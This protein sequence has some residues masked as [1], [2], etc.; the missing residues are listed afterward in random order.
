[1][2][3]TVIAIVVW[4]LLSALA[5]AQSTKDLQK[6]SRT[7]DV[8]LQEKLEQTSK[9]NN[10][11]AIWAG[12]FTL[13]QPDVLCVAGVRKF[14]EPE[15]AEA[16]DV[17]HLGS[18][19]KAMTAVLI[20]QLCTEGKIRLDSTLKEVFSD[21]KEV[22]ESNWGD[23]TLIE[24]MQHRSGAPANMNYFAIE[25]K[26][27]SSVVDNRRSILLRMVSGTR[28]KKRSFV[29]SNVGYIVLGHVIEKLEKKPW[30]QVIEERLFKPLDM[31][32]A[33][34]GPVGLPDTL[35]PNSQ[36]LAHRPWGHMEPISIMEAAR[37]IFGG[38]S[39][40]QLQ[41]QQ[42]DNARCLG[43]AG[44]AHM[45]MKDWSKFVLKFIEPEGKKE[46]KISDEIWNQMLQPAPD[47][48]DHERY[49]GGWIHIDNPPVGTGLFHN[50]SNTTWYCYAFAEETRKTCVLVA[51]NVFN[52]AAQRECDDIAR[53]ILGSKE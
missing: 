35:A 9:K 34:F 2:K 33:S 12:K 1:M 27:S 37:L 28:S 52:Q 11:P 23:A 32:S 45:N 31:Q 21:L 18:C 39:S 5:S 42:L 19:T 8:A 25:G 22:T 48:K 44:R 41:P 24:L 16:N 51:T 30:E 26:Q 50:G 14:G 40:G 10:L 36:V 6:A 7:L 4:C 15:K 53:F 3:N 47:M 20:A 46:L 43:P 13:D 38:G 49:A 29:Y 17:I